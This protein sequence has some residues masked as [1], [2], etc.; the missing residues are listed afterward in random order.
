[1]SAPT[2]T[3]QQ[4]YLLGMLSKGVLVKEGDGVEVSYIS[5]IKKPINSEIDIEIERVYD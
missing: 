2:L 3:E 4:Y 5:E 1:M